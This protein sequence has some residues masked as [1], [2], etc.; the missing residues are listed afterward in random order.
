MGS[1][2]SPGVRT[3]RADENRDADT[4]EALYGFGPTALGCCVALAAQAVRLCDD[5]R[6]RIDFPPFRED[7]EPG[8]I[9]VR[10]PSEPERVEALLRVEPR[11]AG[12]PPRHRRLALLAR[13]A[14]LVL[15]RHRMAREL[16]RIWRD[17]AREHTELAHKLR[18]PLNSAL[19]RVDALLHSDPDTRVGGEGVTRD[20]RG[21]RDSVTAMAESIQGILDVPES[22]RRRPS[23]PRTDSLEPVSIAD[24]LRTVGETAGVPGGVNADADLALVSADR[25]R[26]KD[27]LAEL[28]DLSR[29]ARSAPEITV[30]TDGTGAIR[31]TAHLERSRSAPRQPDSA[32]PGSDPAGWGTPPTTSLA[33]VIAGL[34]GRLWIEAD[35]DAG[36]QVS[37]VLPTTNGEGV[38]DTGQDGSGRT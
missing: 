22:A 23:F 30:A 17:V 38:G 25:D 7:G 20:L 16:G 8:A 6:I 5:R 37:F 36:E 21:L 34:G 27:A 32:A 33:E 28:F 24:L 9:P 29:Q 11:G 35:R 13:H 1:G 26:L 19:L 12:P 2:P 18:G 3:D 31:V 14:G 4:L 10:A 15:E